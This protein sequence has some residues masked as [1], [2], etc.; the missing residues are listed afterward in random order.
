ML[1]ERSRESI[2]KKPDEIADM[3]FA[4]VEKG[5]PGSVFIHSFKRF[6]P[7][8]FFIL[9]LFLHYTK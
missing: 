1:P 7:C 6:F 9:F 4:C 8:Y 5:A 3:G 2:K